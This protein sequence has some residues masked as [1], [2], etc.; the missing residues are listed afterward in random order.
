MSLYHQIQSQMAAG[1]HRKKGEL[2][3]F[4]VEAASAVFTDGSGARHLFVPV[5]FLSWDA[6]VHERVRE[7]RG[8]NS[9]KIHIWITGTATRR[10]KSEL[11]KLGVTVHEQ[12]GKE[13]LSF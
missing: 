7:L 4:S 5:D 2:R 10:A 13:L 11:G 1:Y 12:A 8:D 3:S 9:S 6:N